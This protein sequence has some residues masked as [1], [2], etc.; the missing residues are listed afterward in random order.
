MVLYLKNTTETEFLTRMK[1]IR[2]TE[3]IGEDI[4]QKR[5]FL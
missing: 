5:R 1:F 4:L 2:I 3:G